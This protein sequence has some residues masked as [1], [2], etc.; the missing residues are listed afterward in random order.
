[1][2]TFLL[3]C[4]FCV[5][6]LGQDLYGPITKFK[7][8]SSGCSTA[9]VQS[10]GLKWFNGGGLNESTTA[11]TVT[12]GD[13]LFVAVGWVAGSTATL[14]NISGNGNTFILIDSKTNT[15]SSQLNT[16]YVKNAAGGSTVITAK[17][18]VD[19][20]FGGMLVME[21]SGLNTTSPL[22]QHSIVN[23][24]SPG[25]GNPVNSTTVTT[26]AACEFVAGAVLDQ[27]GSATLG[28]GTGFTLA[29]ATLTGTVGG[30]YQLQTS[31]G[32]I[33]PAFTQTAQFDTYI[34]ANATFKP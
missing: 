19:P 8:T 5:S 17:W 7:P 25:S 18:N 20:N 30:C 14:T 32:A 33:T 26:T 22:D 16:Y 11:I 12:A 27:Q 15:T 2:R 29:P 9:F 24:V 21:A 23:V 4:L 6:C 34:V 31:A 28:A 3:I 1:M 13:M 10:Q